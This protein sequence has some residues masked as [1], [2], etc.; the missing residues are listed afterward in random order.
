MHVAM[1]PDPLPQEREKDRKKLYDS[2]GRQPY[3][4]KFV[5]ETQKLLTAD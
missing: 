5:L 4:C 3:M 1:D 2:I